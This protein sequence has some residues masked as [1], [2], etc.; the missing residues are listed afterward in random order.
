MIQ[1]DSIL[2]GKMG[3]RLLKVSNIRKTIN[4]LQKNGVKHAYYAAKERIEEE[5]KTKYD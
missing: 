4:Y 3:N 1:G 2:L 5:K